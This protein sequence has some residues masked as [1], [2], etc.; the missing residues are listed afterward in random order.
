MI[1]IIFFIIFNNIK[2]NNYIYS[3]TICSKKIYSIIVKNVS[4]KKGEKYGTK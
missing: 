1:I 2:C 3:L 4:K